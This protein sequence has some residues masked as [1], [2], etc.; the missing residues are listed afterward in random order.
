MTLSEIQE[1]IM[2][3]TNNDAEDLG[4]YTPHIDDYINEGYDRIVIIWDNK[5]VPCTDYPRLENG[6]DVPNLPEWIHRYI[7]DWATWLIYRN[8]NPQKQ[9]RGLAF[10]SSFEEMLA[11]LAG[12]GGKDGLGEDGN[13]KKYR[14]F[15]NIPR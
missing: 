3:Q 1:Q 8:G 13:P 11:K 7:A 2:F 12:Q 9:N 10:R 4:D 5:H 14:K 6:T 15:I